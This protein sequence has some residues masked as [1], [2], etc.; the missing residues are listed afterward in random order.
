MGLKPFS[1][2]VLVCVITLLLLVHLLFSW[3]NSRILSVHMHSLRKAELVKF[4]AQEINRWLNLMDMALPNYALLNDQNSQQWLGTTFSLMDSTFFFLEESLAAQQYPMHEFYTFK[5]SIY[6]YLR[7]GQHMQALLE[8]GKRDEFITLL[9]QNRGFRAW[10]HFDEANNKIER[11]ENN[12]IEQS[13]QRY[14]ATV[15]NNIYFFALILFLVLPTLFYTAYYANNSYQY[16]E[17]LRVAGQ[18]RNELL[19]SRN[20]ELEARVKERTREIEAKNIEL[21]SAMQF[22]QKQHQ[23]ITN[24]NEQLKEEVKKQTNDLQLANQELEE[25]VAKMEEYSFVISHKLRSPIANLLGITKLIDLHPNNLDDKLIS[26]LTTSVQEL[27]NII[28]DLNDFL[29]LEKT[30]LQFTDVNIRKCISEVKKRL[31][32]EIE[33]HQVEVNVDLEIKSFYSQHAILT[34]LLYNLLSNAI[35]FR[36]FDRKPRIRIRSYASQVGVKIEVSDNGLGIDLRKNNEKIFKLYQ[37]F[38]LHVKG[39][40]T[41]LYLS[42]LMAEKL[43][44][45][46]KVESVV[47]EGSCFILELYYR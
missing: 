46:L 20:E 47:N 29:L 6:A 7:F 40:G 41:G 4:R 10:K 1:M 24:Q 33:E 38:H 23:T 16:S 13:D 17:K 25:R 15:R 31:S 30:D 28:H 35:R 8:E 18:S 26:Y 21:A 45:S 44:G 5:D 2:Y 12:I 3:H 11:F 9:E 22:I 43:E 19:S 34:N 37:R 39:K 36:D 32:R 42:R 27:D 14:Q